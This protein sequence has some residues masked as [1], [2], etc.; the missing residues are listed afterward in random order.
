M[1]V[2]T[3]DQTEMVLGGSPWRRRHNGTIMIYHR[4]LWKELCRWTNG[5]F[6]ILANWDFVDYAGANNYGARFDEHHFG[7]VERQ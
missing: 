2:L 7:V 6:Q 4:G 5:T 1:D 3:K